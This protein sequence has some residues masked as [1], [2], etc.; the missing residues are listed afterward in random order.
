ME[1]NLSHLITVIVPVYNV[2]NYLKSCID[3]IVKQTYKN[4]EI[5]LIDDGSTDNSGKICDEYALL[6]NRINVVHK[7][8]SGQSDARNIGIKNATGDYFFFVDSD[9]YIE[10]TAIEKMLDISIK[11]NSDL[12]IADI[13]NVDFEK[14][15][16]LNQPN[17]NFSVN[18]D[19]PSAAEHYVLKPWGP[20]NKLYKKHIHEKVLF[21]SG[22]I[23]EDEAIMFQLLKNCKTITET[24][25]KLYYYRQRP[26]STTSKPYSIKKMD[27]FYGWKDNIEYIQKHFPNIEKQALDKLLTTSLYN[28]GNIIL[29]LPIY[30]NH[31]I[32]IINTLKVYRKKMYFN[33]HIKW[34]KKLRL[35]ILLNFNIQIYKSIYKRR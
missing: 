19:S 31:F 26:N 32:E 14:S 24:N 7:K 4:L 3:S 10:F 16:F 5:F 30:E 13:F 20:W 17:N 6:D 28:I 1:N 9:D 11:H 18:Y 2:E 23:H 12:V 22:K 15:T 34:T 29:Q 25:E 33:K 35:W 21:P 8:N 27:W